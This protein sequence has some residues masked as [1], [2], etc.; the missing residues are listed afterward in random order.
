ME[1]KVLNSYL[2]F[3]NETIEIV[4]KVLDTEGKPVHHLKEIDTRLEYN[5]KYLLVYKPN[6]HIG[7]RQMFI[8]EL[9]F[10]NKYVKFVSD[11]SKKIY[12]IYAGG[13]PGYHL[14]ELSRYYPN[15]VFIIFDTNPFI[16]Y[17][18]DYLAEPYDE[19]VRVKMDEHYCDTSYSKKYVQHIQSMDSLRKL[20]EGSKIRIY[21]FKKKCTPDLMVELKFILHFRSY[22]YFWSNENNFNNDQEEYSDKHLITSYLTV[23]EIIKTMQPDA[24]MIK[25]EMPSFNID[26]KNMSKYLDS[27]ELVN[28]NLEL[29]LLNSY[30]KKMVTYPKGKLQLQPWTDKNSTESKLIIKKSNISNLVEYKASEYDSLFNYYN[31]LERPV[32]KHGTFHELYDFGYCECNDCGIEI[33]VFQDYIKNNQ[34]HAIEEFGLEGKNNIIEIL[35]SLSARL[36]CL[37]GTNLEIPDVHGVNRQQYQT[38][39]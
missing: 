4:K 36:N 31:C 24:A 39:P 26:I 12:V 7:M 29:E 1:N 16:T 10:L 28:S 3:D 5:D 34:L 35:G 9:N 37:F 11:E 18:S 14:Y 19:F 21:V 13:S 25:F 17:S 33:K 22:I 8:T 20:I 38:H 2:G 32:R 6:V 15:V 23:F 27:I 30:I